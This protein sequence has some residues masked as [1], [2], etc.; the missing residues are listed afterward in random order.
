MTFNLEEEGEEI[1]KQGLRI[2]IQLKN[3]LNI[4]KVHTALIQFKL[5]TDIIKLL[6]ILFLKSF[7]DQSFMAFSAICAVGL[8]FQGN[9]VLIYH[10]S[11]VQTT[12]SSKVLNISDIVNVTPILSHFSL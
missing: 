12:L 4:R 5:R 6:I 8:F 10:K 1:G 7:F 9:F 3:S 11:F 2:F